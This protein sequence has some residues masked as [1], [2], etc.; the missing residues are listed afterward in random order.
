MYFDRCPHLVDC[1][2]LEE[3]IITYIVTIFM[4]QH[5]PNLEKLDASQRRREKRG[6]F[7]CAQ[8]QNLQTLLFINQLATWLNIILPNLPYD[9]FVWIQWKHMKILQNIL[10]NIKNSH[11]NVGSEREFW[12]LTKGFD[13]T[14]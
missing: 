4:E 3:V 12:K 7:F 6:I 1:N 8:Q 5:Q 13:G 9:T 11:D 14:W 10:E 2:V